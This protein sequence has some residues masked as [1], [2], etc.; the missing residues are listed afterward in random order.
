MVSSKMRQI[1]LALLLLAHLA[2]AGVGGGK[3]DK[4]KSKNSASDAPSWGY[5]GTAGAEPNKW[6]GIC[7]EGQAQVRK[8]I[9]HKS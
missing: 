9:S 4:G 1:L 3:S 8:D 6:G 7:A 5:E 2:H